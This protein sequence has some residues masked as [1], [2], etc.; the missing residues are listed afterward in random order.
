MLIDIRLTL[1]LLNLK[2]F[3]LSYDRES[4]RKTPVA[5]SIRNGERLIGEPAM[6]TVS[7]V[8]L[9][10]RSNLTFW[11]VSLKVN[12]SFMPLQAV[13]FPE[14]TYSHFLDLLGKSIDHPEVERFQE[15]FPYHVITG[16]PDRNS[17]VFHHKEYVLLIFACNLCCHSVCYSAYFFII[18]SWNRGLDFTPEELI[19]MV[20]K[21]AQEIAEEF[22]G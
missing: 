7:F 22:T 1:F 21:K 13:R 16:M 18:L 11:S 5:V 2:Q 3:Y 12:F 9:N 6:V 14:N 15:Q 20:L 19:A 10:D 4:R 8:F 17:V